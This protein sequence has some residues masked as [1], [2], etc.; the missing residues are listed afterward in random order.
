MLKELVPNY[1]YLLENSAAKDLDQLLKNLEVQLENSKIGIGIATDLP[2][3][4]KRSFLKEQS[5][6]TDSISFL[7]NKIPEIKLLSK[8][9][10]STIKADDSIDKQHVDYNK[11]QLDTLKNLKRASVKAKSKPEEPTQEITE[12]KKDEKFKKEKESFFKNN[13]S[14]VAVGKD[15]SKIPVLCKIITSLKDHG[16]FFKN[17]FNK[18]QYEQFIHKMVDYLQKNPELS[19][20]DNLKKLIQSIPNLADANF[21]NLFEDTLFNVLYSNSQA[22][23]LTTIE[24]ILKDI[25]GEES[26]F[27]FT[28]NEVGKIVSY[29]INQ[30]PEE[31]SAY[32]NIDKLILYSGKNKK[33]CDNLQRFLT[34]NNY[35]VSDIFSTS[36]IKKIIA[37]LKENRCFPKDQSQHF[38]DVRTINYDSKEINNFILTAIIKFI[39]E[40]SPKEGVATIIK[41]NQNY[42]EIYP[43]CKLEA[44]LNEIKQG[45]DKEKRLFI[46]DEDPYNLLPLPDKLHSARTDYTNQNKPKPPE[47]LKPPDI[48]KLEP[49]KTTDVITKS[50]ID[51]SIQTDAVL[52]AQIETQT[53]AT[54]KQKTQELSIQTE[55]IP[56]P[57]IE[58]PINIELDRKLR[59]LRKKYLAEEANLKRKLIDIEIRLKE[60]VQ[61]AETLFPSFE[62]LTQEIQTLRTAKQSAVEGRD[63]QIKEQQQLIEK[64]T[65]EKAQIEQQLKKLEETREH[66][67][68]LLTIQEKKSQKTTTASHDA[69]INTEYPNN[70][71]RP[72]IHVPGK[73]AIIFNLK[74]AVNLLDKERESL[75]QITSTTNNPNFKK[76]FWEFHDNQ[77]KIIEKNKLLNNVQDSEH[78]SQSSSMF[79][80]D[81]QLN[82]M[83]VYHNL[84]I[85]SIN[86][87]TFKFKATVDTQETPIDLIK[88]SY[89]TTQESPNKRMVKNIININALQEVNMEGELDDQSCLIMLLS[90]KELVKKSKK[91][92]IDNCESSP[93]TAI[94]LFL[95]GTV[96]GLIPSINEETSKAIENY[97]PSQE[98]MQSLKDCYNII[99]EA[100]LNDVAKRQKIIDTINKLSIPDST[101]DIN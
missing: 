22:I 90:A 85:D 32:Y 16:G 65:K 62:K 11:R 43:V 35:Y 36:E 44:L 54:V 57:P 21:C 58:E 24:P 74:D 86:D 17:V 20:K 63:A 12:E 97:F 28:I 66:L 84:S 45:E 81:H 10:S 87:T 88:V 15:P 78:D 46:S 64:I 59:D 41:N 67:I 37:L 53:S 6:L 89:I 42:K 49:K 79:D 38:N 93:A 18:T 99:S 26:L 69:A 72:K 14:M 75:P 80:L 61:L 3:Y 39:N 73:K 13:I 70:S 76:T 40:N 83:A 23:N 82:L 71:K 55:T 1:S 9:Q 100:T 5:L 92:T 7:S 52:K 68:S 95:F 31:Q 48:E 8:N 98:P 47:A 34:E 77:Q 27:N 2:E 96:L 19:K 33:F 25:L 101:L 91:F 50:T 4:V 29:E 60:Q 56:E 30:V 94:K 51:S